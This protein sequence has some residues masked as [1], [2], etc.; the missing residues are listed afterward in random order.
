[1][2]VRPGCRRSS[3]NPARR[4]NATMSITLRPERADESSGSATSNENWITGDP[5][6]RNERLGGV[7]T[8]PDRITRLVA[9]MPP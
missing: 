6:G 2:R 5:S 3:S 4:P 1:M 7:T 8:L 9:V